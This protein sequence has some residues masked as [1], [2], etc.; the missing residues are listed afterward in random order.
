MIRALI[1]S[2]LVSQSV[3][4][5]QDDFKIPAKLFV[6]PYVRSFAEASK[7]QGVKTDPE[8]VPVFFVREIQNDTD[9]VGLCT[10]LCKKQ[11]TL[12]ASIHS[13][14]CRRHIDI[15]LTHW[16]KYSSERREVL[17][18]HELGHCTLGREHR[19]TKK[20]GIPISIM[21]WSISYTP[22]DPEWYRMH[23][24]ALE[25]ELFHPELYP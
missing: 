7:R 20:H 17:V 16:V 12:T 11:E 6:A 19:S 18:W 2:L 8:N 22:D 23:K 15:N 1:A 9:I 24:A 10:I 5:R 25:S 4:G 14:Y 21:Y 13:P 3:S